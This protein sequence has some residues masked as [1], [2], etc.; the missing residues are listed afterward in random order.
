[1]DSE[2]E[3]KFNKY[4][5]EVIKKSHLRGILIGIF[6]GMLIG[7]ALSKSSFYLGI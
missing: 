1:M 6:I 4:L 3:I 7:F 2:K 5:S